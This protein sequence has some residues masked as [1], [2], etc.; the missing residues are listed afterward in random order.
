MKSNFTTPILETE[1]NSPRGKRTSRHLVKLLDMV[2]R[3][4]GLS[5]LS[6]E[7]YIETCLDKMTEGGEQVISIIPD[8][9]DFLVVLAVP[10][11]GGAGL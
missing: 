5:N 6:T 11:T 8:G 4:S 9:E 1:Q 10:V 3:P 7:E 2:E